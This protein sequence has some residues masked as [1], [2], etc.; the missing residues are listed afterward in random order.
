MAGVAWERVRETYE[1]CCELSLEQRTRYLERLERD[2]PELHKH[3]HRLITATPPSGGFL[4]RRPLQVAGG[5]S[6][7]HAPVVDGFEVLERLGRG[8]MG[9]VWLARQHRPSRQVAL[10]TLRSERLDPRLLRR[11][12]LEAELLARL[13]HPAIARVYSSGTYL[14]EDGREEPYFAMEYVPGARHLNEVTAGLELED[15]LDLFVAVCEGVQDAHGRGVLHRDLKPGNIL[16]DERG[17]PKVIDFGIGRALEAQE[18]QALTATGELLGTLAYMAPEQLGLFASEPD[19]RCD[20]YALGAIL[21][22]LLAGRRPYCGEN[23]LSQLVQRLSSGVP[24]DLC[25]RARDVPKDLG[26]IVGRAMELEPQRRYPTVAAL[27][28]DLRR[29]RRGE[30]VWAGPRDRLYVW[31]K[32]VRRH[33][34]GVA[35]SVGV[36]A[37]A[38]GILVTA[39]IGLARERAQALK[40]LQLSD[41][42]KLA[43]LVAREIG[44]GPAVP[45]QQRAYDAWLDDAVDLA[46]RLPG[47]REVLARLRDEARSGEDAE[48]RWWRTNLEGLVEDL[49]AFTAPELGTLARVRARRAHLGEVQS[50]S[51]AHE[52]AARR[53]AEALASIA[54]REACPRYDG[55]ELEPQLGLLPLRRNPEGLWEFAHLASGEEPPLLPDGGLELRPESCIVL[56]LVPGGHCTV[57]AVAPD[58]R[59]PLGSPHVDSR[60][61][62]TEGPLLDVELEPFFLAKHELTQAQWRR[63]TGE[64]PSQAASGAR[65]PVESVSWDECEV[66]LRHWALDFPSE[67]QWEVAY[68][69]GASSPWWFGSEPPPDWARWANFGDESGATE[70]VGLRDANPLGFADLIG[71]VSEWCSDWDTHGAPEV[72]VTPGNG[73]RIASEGTTKIVRGASFGIPYG[74]RNSVS[75]ATSAVVERPDARKPVIGIRPARALDQGPT[76]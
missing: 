59:H 20:V 55:L 48:R 72:R 68:R 67:A 66:V 34:V 41:A 74:F 23:D 39:S 10:K 70:P 52:D 61:Y 33:K 19:A 42:P 18:S 25:A 29:F 53:W 75:R 54:D 35:S 4:E 31:G 5:V 45:A 16:V 11:F 43:E 28:E 69:A 51:L 2:E 56:V 46:D 26:W 30:P 49:A 14:A 50:R 73:E 40:V 21:F 44:L 24:P 47:H 17:Q 12:E 22:E 32:Y 38:I 7:G 3:V 65:H 27:A 9:D 8:G 60:A 63:A 71:N 13:D 64:S 37:A 1:R 58:E 6:D 57:G 15:K 62:D 36:A 76:R